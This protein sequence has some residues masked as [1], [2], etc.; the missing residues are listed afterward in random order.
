M[1]IV[2]GLQPIQV[3]NEQRKRSPA[4]AEAPTIASSFCSTSADRLWRPVRSSVIARR[5]N[6]RASPV[7]FAVLTFH[8]A[9]WD[10]L[11]IAVFVAVGL[12]T[13]KLTGDARRLHLL[14][15]TDDLTGLH[16]L[17][18]FEQKLEAMVR[19]PATAGLRLRCWSSTWIG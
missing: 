18:S 15:M 2:Q 9:H 17:R 3:D 1:H 8:Y 6:R 11:Q 12:I 4:V 10:V 13:A 14:A 19:T 7:S 16:N 5:C